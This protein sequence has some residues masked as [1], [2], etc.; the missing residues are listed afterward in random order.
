VQRTRHHVAGWGGY[1][2]VVAIGLAVDQLTKW[3]VTQTMDL[4]Q[5]VPLLGEIVSLTHVRNTG[6]AFSLLANV[7]AAWKLY[8]FAGIAV[9]AFAAMTVAAFRERERGAAWLLPL[10]LVSAGS[11]GNLIDRLTVRAVIDFIDV[12]YRSFH[13]PVFNVAD[14]AVCV[15]VAW[16]VLLSWN[17]G[18]A[19]VKN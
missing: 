19:T 10:G 16:L 6:A 11:L 12:S 18:K 9:I 4:N 3:I 15:G 2:M 5:S 8:L 17:D 7:D 13:F 1:W 14:S